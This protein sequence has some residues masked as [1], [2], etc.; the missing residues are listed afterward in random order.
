MASP[1][2]AT[3]FGS[4]YDAAMTA[5]GRRPEK[6]SPSIATIGYERAAMADFI[7]TL[8]EAGIATL[9]DI[10]AN[11]WSR[12]GDFTARPLAD[13]LSAAGISYR[14]LPALGSPD[15]A[16]HAARAGDATGF[17]R[18]YRAQLATPAAKTALAEVLATAA[19]APVC[20]MCYERDPRDCHRRLTAEALASMA[21]IEP[22]H[23]FVAAARPDGAL[24]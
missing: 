2:G 16:R 12:R 22:R 9:I 5:A 14:H 8:A 21:D 19:Q 20:L 15:A 7:R 23:L 4:R 6:R 1:G 10:R 24:L 13:A 17:E 3:I 11:A 18:H